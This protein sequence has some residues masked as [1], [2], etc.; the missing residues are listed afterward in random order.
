[1]SM[2]E[3][4]VIPTATKYEVSSL[5]RVRRIAPYRTTTPG[6]ILSVNI[7]EHGYARTAIS[8]DGVGVKSAQIHRLVLMAFVGLPPSEQHLGAHW[9]GVRNDNRPENLRWATPKENTQDKRR[10]GT[11]QIGAGNPNAKLSEDDVN[12]IRSHIMYGERTPV[13]SFLFQVT[14]TTIRKI[15]KGESWSHLEFQL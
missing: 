3:W 9:N 13:L 5:G 12:L 1:M 10:H 7:D 11:Y 6:R 4:R 2:E 14:E 15:A 8:F